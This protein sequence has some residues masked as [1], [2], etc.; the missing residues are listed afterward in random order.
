MQNSS[1]IAEKFRAKHEMGGVEKNG[2]IS[3]G[4]RQYQRWELSFEEK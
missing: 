1:E 4:A 3:T 2:F